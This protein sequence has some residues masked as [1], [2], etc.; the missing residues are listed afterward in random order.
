MVLIFFLVF[1]F[2][3]FFP[4]SK[5]GWVGGWEEFCLALPADA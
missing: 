1:N 5:E 4:K 3:V 2:G